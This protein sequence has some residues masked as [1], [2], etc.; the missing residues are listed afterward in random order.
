[1]SRVL[2]IVR[3]LA[4]L[5]AFAAGSCASTHHNGPPARGPEYKH[6]TAC[7]GAS[8]CGGDQYCFSGCCKNLDDENPLE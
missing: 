7:T 5:A 8:E 4:L 2:S 3:V 6:C 1:M